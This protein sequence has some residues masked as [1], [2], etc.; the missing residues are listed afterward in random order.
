MLHYLKAV[1]ETGTDDTDTVLAKMREMPVEDMFARNGRLRED[2]L[3]VHDM[4]LLQVK[5]PEESKFSWDYYHVRA[6]IPGDEAFRPLSESKC[7][8]VAA[9]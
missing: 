8:H 5:S 2:G 7:P 3:M 1:H 6:V 4:Y 9:N